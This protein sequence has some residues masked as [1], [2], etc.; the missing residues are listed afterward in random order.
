VKRQSNQAL[1]I[2]DSE[3]PIQN[4]FYTAK[5]STIIYINCCVGVWQSICLPR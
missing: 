2:I 1:E 3:Q 5:R 4:K